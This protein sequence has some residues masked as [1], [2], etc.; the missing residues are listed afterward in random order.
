MNKKQFFFS[1]NGVKISFSHM[2]KARIFVLPKSG[3]D[4]FNPPPPSLM[5]APLFIEEENSKLPQ[6]YS[7]CVKFVAFRHSW[8][9]FLFNILIAFLWN[10]LDGLDKL[11]WICSVQLDN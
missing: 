5:V 10:N 9:C 2:V 8:W 3:P 11:A 1:I 4:C 7:N 6:Q